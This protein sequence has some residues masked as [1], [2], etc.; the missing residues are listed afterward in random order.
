MGDHRIRRGAAG[1]K[2]L[3]RI[4]CASTWRCADDP[5]GG[6]IKWAPPTAVSRVGWGSGVWDEKFCCRS[7]CAITSSAS[8]I[9]IAARWWP[10]RP[11]HRGG[12]FAARALGLPER[13][14]RVATTR[15][16][17]MAALPDF[18]ANL[19]LAFS[20]MARS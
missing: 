16:P 19:L 9:C 15:L 2:S 5:A 14:L 17:D 18:P 6:A 8:N 20:P 4:L 1:I 13:N 12:N 7:R 10:A 3:D 11:G